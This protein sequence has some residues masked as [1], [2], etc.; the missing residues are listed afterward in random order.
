M[1]NLKTII[2]YPLLT[3]LSTGKKSFENMGQFIKKSGDTVRRLLQPSSTSFDFS[4]RICQSIFKGKKKLFFTID[5]TLIKKIH[6]QY[7]QGAGMFYDTKIGRRIMAYRL[8]VGLLSDGKL[9]IPIDCAYLFS[10]ELSDQIAPKTLSKDDIAIAT[11][12]KAQ[13]LFPDAKII[14]LADGLYATKTFLAWCKDND[15]PAELR[16]HS[17]RV[18]LFNGERISLKKISSERGCQPKGRQMARTIS[19]Q[20]HSIDLE[21]T[22]VKRVDKNDLETIV[23]QVATYKTLPREHVAHYKKRW[24]IEKVFRT[25]KQYLGL[26]ECFSRN[27]DTQRNHV[28]SVLLAYSLAQLDMKKFRLKTP[29]LA[30]KRLKKKN[31]VFSNSS[32]VRNQ[33]SFLHFDA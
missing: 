5:D 6:S 28:A 27:F 19:V 11:I 13:A 18:V 10:K 9:S 29:E 30:I 8:V 3:L 16:M 23:F 15:V 24:P 26:Q 31:V 2:T 22:I 14:V 20:W 32:F 4:Q 17:N 1:L 33:K 12:R 7:M 21:V 25:C